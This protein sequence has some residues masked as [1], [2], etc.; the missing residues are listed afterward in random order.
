MKW[1]ELKPKKSKL[2]FYLSLL[3]VTVGCAT[4]YDSLHGLD[5]AEQ[6]PSCLDTDTNSMEVCYVTWR[7]SVVDSGIPLIMEVDYSGFQERE[8]SNF[9]LMKKIFWKEQ[10]LV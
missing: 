8:R 7:W 4:M 10:E 2:P 1:E 6:L 3:V 5:R 9:E